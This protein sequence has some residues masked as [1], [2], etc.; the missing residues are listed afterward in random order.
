MTSVDRVGV[1]IHTSINLSG[2]DRTDLGPS[3]LFDFTKSS[4]EWKRGWFDS[5]Y[6]RISTMTA[7]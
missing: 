3:L 4:V 5:F 2:P 1:C 7:I 6:A